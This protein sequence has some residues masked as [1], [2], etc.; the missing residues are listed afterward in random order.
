M[1][2]Q[3]EPASGS[4]AATGGPAEV[5]APKQPEVAKKEKKRKDTKSRSKVW[6][7]FD[8]IFEEG[9]L[10]KA[11][12]IYYAKKL[13]AD[14][15]INGTS[16]IRNHMLICMKNPNPKSIRR[17]L[18]TLQP[19]LNNSKNWVLLGLGSLI[20]MLLGR[21]C[22]TCALLMSFL[23]NLLRERVSKILCLLHALGLRYLVD[24]P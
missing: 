20:M 6:E 14:P 13:H 19:D 10:V 21:H 12:C 5:D 4:E 3:A 11:K 18:L 8:K 22:L 1:E 24:G 15:K 17:S 2:T 7:H 16:S 23:L 9:K